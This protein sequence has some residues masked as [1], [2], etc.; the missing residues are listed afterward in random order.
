MVGPWGGLV[1]MTGWIQAEVINNNMSSADTFH[2]T[3][4]TSRLPA[5]FDA[6]WFST[7]HDMYVQIYMGN[8]SDPENYSTADLTS[9]IFGQVDSIEYD[10]VQHTLDLTGRDLTRVFIDTKSTQKYPNLTSSQ[11]ATN[12]AVAHGLTPNVA[13]TKGLV[14]KYYEIDHVTM[15][16]ERSDWDLLLYLASVENFVVYVRNQTLYFQPKQVA[17]TQNPWVVAWQTPTSD[18][19]YVAANVESLNF[20]RGLTVSRGV[21]VTIRSWNHKQA[22]GFT[23]SFPSGAKSIQ[24][25]KSAP[26]GGAQNYVRTFPNLTPDQAL[27]KAKDL[28]NQ[29]IAHEMKLSFEAPGDVIL[30][31]TSTIKITGTNTAYDQNYF[32]DSI[33]RHI[34]F[35]GGFSM[36]VSAKNHA[37]ETQAAL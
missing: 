10:P 9:F 31:T 14:G 16:D 5:G 7:Q 30:D 23:V 11:I 12:L 15:T 21:T 4:A 3:F 36:H 6:N 33:A 37:P 25:G 2:V 28:Y 19:N 17:D 22:K 35:D 24:A 8:V 26:F 34:A 29:I 13:Q 32:P 1:R 27:Q 20:S 18:Q